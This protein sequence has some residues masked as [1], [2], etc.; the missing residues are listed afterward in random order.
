MLNKFQ[1]TLQNKGGQ[2][3]IDE[4]DMAEK[5]RTKTMEQTGNAQFD[6][7]S[8]EQEQREKEQGRLNQMV[9]ALC[10]LITAQIASSRQSSKLKRS[11]GSK[12]VEQNTDSDAKEDDRF[13]VYHQ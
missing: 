4:N 5:V 11:K 1:N 7:D 2:W 13:V 3:I 8:W 12:P 6:T 10:V 9:D